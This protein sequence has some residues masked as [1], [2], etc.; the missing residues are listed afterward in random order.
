MAAIWPNH[1]KARSLAA[2]RGSAACA[3]SL[4]LALVDVRML[5][6]FV[7]AKRQV[8]SFAEHGQL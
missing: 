5:N 8:H 3:L 6:H 7:L 4:A 1:G 2:T